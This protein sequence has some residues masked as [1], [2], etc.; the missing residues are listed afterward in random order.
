[1]IPLQQVK[2]TKVDQTKDEQ[3]NTHQTLQLWM[4]HILLLLQVMMMMM[5]MMMT[6][7]IMTTTTTMC[8]LRVHGRSW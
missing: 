2:E 8:R 3:I 1:M 6:T 7:T 4:A 5:M